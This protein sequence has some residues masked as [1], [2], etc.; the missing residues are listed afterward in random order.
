MFRPCTETKKY[1]SL[2]H[3]ELTTCFLCVAGVQYKVFLYSIPKI[4][5]TFI[6]NVGSNTDYSML[7]LKF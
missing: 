7:R 3:L 5:T 1:Q 2:V 4:K 6:I